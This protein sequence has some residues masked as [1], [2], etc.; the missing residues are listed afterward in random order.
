MGC[1]RGVAT[2]E[3]TACVSKLEIAR[4]QGRFAQGLLG[5][6]R[7]HAVV[8]AGDVVLF[9]AVMVECGRGASQ[10]R[11]REPDCVSSASAAGSQAG[12]D[13]TLAPAVD[14]CHGSEDHKELHDG[15][16]SDRRRRRCR[17]AVAEYQAKDHGQRAEQH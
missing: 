13:S 12:V 3:S 8:P 10:G 4:G 6:W 16:S 14:C 17:E 7:A 1:R 5:R 2:L 9:A 11:P 15:Q